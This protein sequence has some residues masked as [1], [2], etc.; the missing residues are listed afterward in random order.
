MIPSFTQLL[1][2][3]ICVGGLLGLYDLLRHCPGYTIPQRIQALEKWEAPWDDLKN[4]LGN[5]SPH[6]HD[7]EDVVAL[8]FI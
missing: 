2:Y 3:L 4:L 5:G 6:H 7:T 8:P 1:Q